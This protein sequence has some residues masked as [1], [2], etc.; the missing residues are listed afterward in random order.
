[1]V[2]E[3]LPQGEVIGVVIGAIVLFSIISFVP[4]VITR[5]HRRHAARRTAGE[6]ATLTAPMEQVSVERW[7][8]E[9]NSPA[10]TD[11]YAQDTC[12]ICLSSLSSS[13][14]LPLPEPACLPRNQRNLASPPPDRSCACGTGDPRHGNCI[15]V[16]N[17]C[18]HVFHLS[19][20]T[21][22][23]EYRRYQCPICQASYSPAETAQ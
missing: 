10:H 4:I 9:Q 11:Q 23:F 20:L 7:L 6:V 12:P 16:L 17:R 1:M 15:I 13:P 19:C 21:S 2:D 22:W 18:H 8:E 14:Y 5:Y 3:A